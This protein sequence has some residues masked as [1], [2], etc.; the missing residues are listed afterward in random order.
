MKW[1]SKTTTN[2]EIIDS[3]RDIVWYNERMTSYEI[4][5]VVVISNVGVCNFLEKR[6][7]V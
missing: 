4:A 5:D 3:V 2:K 7:S 1:I 6:I